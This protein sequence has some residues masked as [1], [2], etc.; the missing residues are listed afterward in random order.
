[1]DAKTGPQGNCFL[2]PAVCDVG[3]KS[4]AVVILERRMGQVKDLTHQYDLEV[5]SEAVAASVMYLSG[6]G[7]FCYWFGSCT[8]GGKKERKRRQAYV[9]VCSDISWIKDVSPALS[10]HKTFVALLPRLF[11]SLA[12]GCCEQS[13]GVPWFPPANLL[14]F[15]G[16]I[17]HD[18]KRQEMIWR[19]WTGEMLRVFY[20][21]GA[22]YSLSLSLALTLFF[23]SK[24]TVKFLFSTTPLLNKTLTQ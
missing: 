4:S 16:L 7:S 11:T 23:P 5:E 24:I 19:G 3:C 9:K 6:S 22:F 20:W 2:L 14:F 13:V 10:P 21:G 15:Q 12:T 17:S 8:R 18:F 1:M